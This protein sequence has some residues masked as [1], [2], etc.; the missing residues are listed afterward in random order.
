MVEKSAVLYTQPVGNRVVKVKINSTNG[1]ATKGNDCKI[2][3]QN[4]FRI[5]SSVKPHI[6]ISLPPV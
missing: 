6:N 3:K 5:C 4:T 1:T 2:S